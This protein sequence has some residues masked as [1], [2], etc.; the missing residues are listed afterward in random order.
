[1]KHNSNGKS[2]KYAEWYIVPSGISAF[3]E[4]LSI[5]F[6]YLING[7]PF[8][9][10]ADKTPHKAGTSKK[11]YVSRLSFFSCEAYIYVPRGKQ[12]KMDLKTHKCI[13]VGYNENL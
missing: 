7:S 11:P 3:K 12:S 2:Q 5:L 8:S 1:M 6:C 10:L 13:L 9:T 4:R